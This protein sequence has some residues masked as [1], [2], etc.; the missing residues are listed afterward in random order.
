MSAAASKICVICGQ[1]CSAKPRVKDH[2]GRYYCTGCH[3]SARKKAVAAAAASVQSA[4]PAAARPTA[5]RAA[6]VT[7]A[8]ASA[9]ARPARK[10]TDDGL[11]QLAMLEEASAGVG[12]T[13]SLCANCGAFMAPDAVLCTTCGFNTQTGKVLSSAMLAP[14]AATA[15]ARPARSGGGFDFG[16][17]LKQPW[18]FSVV[19]AVLMLGFYFLASGDDELEG[20]FRLLTGIY[21]LVVGLWLLVAAFGVSAGTGIMCLCIPFYALYFVF[22][23]NTNSVLKH[24][25]L[26]SLLASVLNITLGP[27]WQQ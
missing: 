11:A 4:R 21:Q 26:A 24:A 1:E 22:S 3:E 13:G 2:N 23:V 8:R 10:P 25:F 17:L 20:A 12:T 27:F 5:A 6:P 16:N 14:A 7:A 15:T 19:P 9:A 18:L